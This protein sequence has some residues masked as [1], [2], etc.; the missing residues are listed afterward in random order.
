MTSRP[1]DIWKTLCISI[2]ILFMTGISCKSVNAQE[3]TINLDNVILHKLDLE[4]FG[5]VND[6]RLARKLPTLSWDDVLYRAA[7]DQ[8]DYLIKEKSLS[9]DQ[10]SKDKHTAFKRVKL[11]GGEY[12]TGVGENL[13][14]MQLGIVLNHKGKRLS[15]QSYT[16]AARTMAQVWKTSP[17]HYKNILQ[18]KFNV[19]A[20]ATAY[21]SI[22][23][24]L[25][26]VQVFGFTQLQVK[27]EEQPDNAAE[28]LNMPARKIPFGLKES[29]ELRKADIKSMKAFMTLKTVNGFLFG[30]YRAG[31]K[32]FRGHRSAVAV[33]HIPLAQYDSGAVEY[34]R[35]RNRRNGL[36]P[37]NGELEKPSYRREMLRVSKSLSPR[38]VWLDLRIM[39]LYRRKKVFCFPVN[40]GPGTHL[41]LI[42]KKRL[43]TYTTPIGLPA[44]LL[45]EPLPE[46]KFKTGFSEFKLPQN[47]RTEV[48]LDTVQIKVLYATGIVNPDTAM[49][50]KI[51][52]AVKVIQGKVVSVE[53]FAYASVDGDMIENQQ[54]A[55]QRANAFM[56]L[57][58]AHLDTLNVTPHVVTKE[59]WE[60][61]FQ[62]IA[63]NK[64]SH[65]KHLHK[66]DL[67]NYV[68]AH[69]ND[70]L[71]QR[72]LA[73][74]RFT[75]FKMVIRRDTLIPLPAEKAVSKYYIQKKK[76]ESMQK[77]T[78]S[79]AAILEQAQLKAYGEM[80]ANN[81][82]DTL[83]IVWDDHFPSLQY[84]HLMFNYLFHG[85]ISDSGLY[86]KLHNLGRLK[87]F[88]GKVK[89]QLVYNNMVLIY[90][91]YNSLGAVNSMM[92]VSRLFC[93]KYRKSEFHVRNYRR[94]RCWSSERRFHDKY[95]LLKEF[96]QLI[97]YTHKQFKD[98]NTDSLQKFY[99]TSVIRM[100]YFYTPAWPKEIF[101]HL[102][103]IKAL[104]HPN[105][106]ALTP[107]ERV[108]LALFYNAF[109][110]TDVARHLLAPA[111]N[112][113]QLDVEGRKLYITLQFETYKDEHTFVDY[114]IDQHATLGNAAWCDLLT[115]GRYLSHVLL[116]DMKLKKFYNCNC[117]GKGDNP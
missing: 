33:E 102:A 87:S 49:A 81:I 73:E 98:L 39:K 55:R 80:I 47:F 83:A 97:G 114:L 56:N 34:A 72:L 110:K 116:E 106:N 108:R 21:D 113:P 65:L 100:L 23:Q 89:E 38:E 58:N 52:H 86:V 25:V 46:L 96:P 111:I 70:S 66:R 32:A 112:D 105:D 6:L 75:L 44:D 79:Q 26:A 94:L 41:F 90:K 24:R 61:F 78:T 36:Y 95:Y 93:T 42:N 50:R 12:F 77:R 48:K 29:R 109:Y 63:Q 84:H 60:L 85:S 2:L 3:P 71:I 107:A 4:T 51:Q 31:K 14:S 74:Q 13:V 68:N 19:T 92:N 64:L 88:Q 30:S 40:A 99:T 22:S 62:Q 45:Y 91:N 57:I 27:A 35:V 82:A 76:F 10:P 17:L 15:T 1:R 103:K 43:I 101:L 7:K 104:Y 37:L 59:Q 8:A 9:H 115:G 53:A 16:S 5:A 67:R 54:L 28:L 11:H 117:Q 20:V 69:K 18:K